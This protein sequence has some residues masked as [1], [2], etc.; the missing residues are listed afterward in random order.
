MQARHPVLWPGSRAALLATEQGEGHWPTQESLLHG[1]IGLEEGDV[2]LQ[3][4]PGIRHGGAQALQPP[5]ALLDTAIA[6]RVLY[7]LDA[8]P[9]V[10]A[11]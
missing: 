9:C 7:R 6:Q 3:R 4:G 10:L 11:Y 1:V 5:Q 2:G 8:A